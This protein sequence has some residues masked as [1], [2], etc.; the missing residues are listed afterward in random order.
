M[1][2]A[3]GDQ[4][5]GSSAAQVRSTASAEGM[6]GGAWRDRQTDRDRDRDRNRN[7][8]RDR[9]RETDRD[10]DRDIHRGHGVI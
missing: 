2:G 3:S 9:E 4:R 8:N 7:R 6:R 10:R 1:L 5:G